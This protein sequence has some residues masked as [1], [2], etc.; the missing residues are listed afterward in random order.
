MDAARD[1]VRVMTV[2]GAKGLEATRVILAD[3]CRIDER[4]PPLVPMALP[5]CGDELSGLTVPVWS[6]RKD[7]DPAAVATAREALRAQAMEEH[8][9]LLTSP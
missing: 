8:N 1:E 2:H 4:G 7:G 3:G 9:R 6:P 5:E